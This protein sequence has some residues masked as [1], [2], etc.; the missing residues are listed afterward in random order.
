MIEFVTGTVQFIDWSHL[1][2]NQAYYVRTS[3]YY[4]WINWK[5]N[6]LSFQSEVILV[7]YMLI[8]S[9]FPENYCI[10]GECKNFKCKTKALLYLFLALK[11]E[12]KNFHTLLSCLYYGYDPLHGI[13]SHL[14]IWNLPNPQVLLPPV[15]LGKTWNGSFRF[16]KI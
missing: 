13:N 2:R 11:L 14:E 4:L 15:F 3:K 7:R 6:N 1:K 16:L 9:H 10:S 8:K 5:K 12:H